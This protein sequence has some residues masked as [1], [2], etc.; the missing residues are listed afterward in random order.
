ANENTL[1]LID[2]ADNG[3]FFLDEIHRLPKESQEKLFSLLDSGQFYPLGENDVPHKVNVRFVFATTEKLDNF[4][5]KTFMRRVPLHVSLPSFKDR[6]LT[7][8]LS[9]IFNAFK[10]E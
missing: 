4:L 5:L 7:E 8:R 9:L 10:N 3:Y 1:G 2:R 6:P